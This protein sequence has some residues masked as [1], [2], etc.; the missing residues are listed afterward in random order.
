MGGPI[1]SFRHRLLAGVFAVGLIVL[2]V[3]V[4]GAP[5]FRWEIQLCRFLQAQT[6]PPVTTILET[7]SWV[8]DFPGPWIAGAIACVGLLLVRR[9][10]EAGIL[11][12]AL[13]TGG[14]LTMLIKHW[15]RRPRP[16]EPLVMV[17]KAYPHES[18]PSGHVV[19]LTTLAGFFLLLV[20]R[21]ETRGDLVARLGLL[22]VFAALTGMSRIYMGAHWPLDVL[23]GFLLAGLILVAAD[24]L[25]PR[26]PARQDPPNR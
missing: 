12:A 15:T 16:E 21:P 5:P 8:G 1:P 11:A 6:G 14:L 17:F 23:G 9:R 24:Q 25:L 7:L 4:S 13:S 3:S 18:F 20:K 26:R 22:L 19:F 2:G 10:H